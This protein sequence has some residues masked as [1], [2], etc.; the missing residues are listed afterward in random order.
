MN[1]ILRFRREGPYTWLSN[2]HPVNVVLDDLTYP[3]VEHAFQ[4]A[5]CDPDDPARVR[6]QH[7]RNPAQVKKLGRKV[8]LRP[9]W[10]EVKD[11]VLEDLLRQKFC[12]PTLQAKLLQTE[13]DL[14]V[15]SNYWHDNYW[16]CC[17]ATAVRVSVR[18]DSVRSSWPSASRCPGV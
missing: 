14:I 15:E 16:G 1:V 17:T 3:S 13:D 4:A 18:T 2:F 11:A 5:K 10:E 7:E 12:D 9:D 6:I 8:Q